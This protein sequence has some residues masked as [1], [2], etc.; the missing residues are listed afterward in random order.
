MRSAQDSGNLQ[1]GAKPGTA[2][3][4]HSQEA[5]GL[6]TGAKAHLSLGL[7]CPFPL[8]QS[9]REARYIGQVTVSR[10]GTRIPRN[11]FYPRVGNR[12]KARKPGLRGAEQPEGDKLYWGREHP[13]LSL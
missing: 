13:S 5:L 7:S 8:S 6:G 4:A 1:G 9:P 2:F 3:I 12:C 11:Q 10:S